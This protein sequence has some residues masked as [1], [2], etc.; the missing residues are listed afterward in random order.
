[1]TTKITIVKADKEKVTFR[2]SWPSVLG[3]DTMMS[4]DAEVDRAEIVKLLEALHV[5]FLED[6]PTGPR[7]WK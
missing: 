4:V 2:A 7:R 3:A 5:A 6:I 1:M